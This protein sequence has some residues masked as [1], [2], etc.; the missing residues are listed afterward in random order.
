MPRDGYFACLASGKSATVERPHVLGM[1]LKPGATREQA[2]FPAE[3]P[4]PR[5]DPRLPAAYAHPRRRAILAARR[6][7][8]RAELSA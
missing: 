4:P 2:Y 7:K 6:R 1:S 5:E 3:Q 8:G